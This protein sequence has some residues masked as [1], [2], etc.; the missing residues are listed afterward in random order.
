MFLKAYNNENQKKTAKKNIHTDWTEHKKSQ[1]GDLHRP[2]EIF[3]PMQIVYVLRYRTHS[4][5]LY[6]MLI[7]WYVLI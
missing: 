1:E 7:T 6:L 5:G 3:D 2:L 4:L